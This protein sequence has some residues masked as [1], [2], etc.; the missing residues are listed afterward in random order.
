LVQQ[1][2]CSQNPGI[3]QAGVPVGGKENILNLFGGSD[4]PQFKA[5]A[6]G[7]IKILEPSLFPCFGDRLFLVVPEPEK[8]GRVIPEGSNFG[9]QYPD[10]DMIFSP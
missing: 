3:L 9:D 10:G 8:L 2:L 1:F 5:S 7:K 4:Q 6:D